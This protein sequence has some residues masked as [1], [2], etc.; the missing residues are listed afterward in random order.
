MNPSLRQRILP[1]LLAFFS[2]PVLAAEAPPPPVSPAE[3]APIIKAGDVVVAAKNYEFD[4]KTG[5]GHGTGGVRVTFQDNVMTADEVKYDSLHQKIWAKGNVV[6]TSERG[7][8]VKGDTTE[9]ADSGDNGTVWKCDEITGNFVTRQFEMGKYRAHSGVVYLAGESASATLE[10]KGKG[11]TVIHQGSFTTCDLAET[12]EPH[13]KMT[14]NRIVYHA[15]GSF[16]AYNAVIKVGT[17]PVLYLPAMWGTTAGEGE[18]DVKPGV[19]GRWGAY[20][21]LSKS[22]KLSDQVTTKM[23][24]DLYSKR[25]VAIGNETRIVTDHSD[26]K[27]R[28]YGIND[29]DT[30]K[31][32][33]AAGSSKYNRRFDKVPGR[34]RAEG[35]HTQELGDGLNLRMKV[36]KMSDIDMMEDWFREEFR[37]NPQP[38]SFADVTLDSE[39]FSLSL[40]ARKRVNDFYSEAEQLPMLKL[41]M[42]RQALGDTNIYYESHSSVGE[43]QMSFRKFDKHFVGITEPTDYKALRA[44]S[45]HMFYYPLKLDNDVELVPRAGMRV[46]YY[47]T[48]SSQRLTVNDLDAMMAADDPDKYL[49]PSSVTKNYDSKGGSRLRLASELGLEA[50][51]KYYRTWADYQSAR[52][53]IDGLRHV[54]QPYINYTYNPPPTEDRENLYFFDEVDRLIEQNFIRLG[55]RQRWETR[56]SNRIY[57]LASLENYADFHFIRGDGKAGP[58]DF[59]TRFRFDPKETFGLWTNAAVDM[60]TGNLHRAEIGFGVGDQKVFRTNISYLYRNNYAARSVYSMGSTLTDAVGDS[61]FAHQYDRVHYVCLGFLFPICAKTRGEVRFEFDVMEQKLARQIYE[62]TRDLHC[63]DGALRL[64]VDEGYGTSLML[65]FTLKAFPGFKVGGGL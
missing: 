39:R 28:L 25:G 13:Y 9:A 60:Q 24:L 26:T 46:T 50:S 11:E 16:T 65:I 21:L 30:P 53:D 54:V 48:S 5:L 52:W 22:W 56:R 49:T 64:E 15:D 18:L 23:H 44:D 20:L 45:L 36:D 27:T 63:W 14:S 58:G 2:V 40:S 35:Y 38:K 6:M 41:D 62:I 57:T 3:P 7:A 59:G 61:V 33:D 37:V 31:T 8:K 43:M 29:N 34:Y 32:R 17:V 47:D 12:G 1:V 55:L 51:T 4:S 42:P 10:G 19:S